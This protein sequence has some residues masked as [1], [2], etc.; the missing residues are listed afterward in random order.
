M[1][2]YIHHLFS[3]SLFEILFHNTENKEWFIRDDKTGYVTLEYKSQKYHVEFTNEIHDKQDGRHIISFYQLYRSMIDRDDDRILDINQNRKIIVDIKNI[4]KR[5]NEWIGDKKGWWVDIIFGE[6]FHDFNDSEVSDILKSWTNHTLLTELLYFNNSIPN[7]LF[8]L[9]QTLMFW[10]KKTN[11]M[12]Y[13]DYGK[14]HKMIKHPYPLGFQ[15]KRHRRRRLEIG[16]LLDKTNTFVSQ[17]RWVDEVISH[18]DSYFKPIEGA[19]VNELIGKSEFENRFLSYMVADKVGMDIF[20]LLYPQ[21]RIQILDETQSSDVYK[22]IDRINILFLSEKTWGMLIGNMGF[23][24]THTF[25]L[26]FISKQILGRPYPFYDKIK[27]LESDTPKL[28]E[29]INQI[30]QDEDKIQE[31]ESWVSEMHDILMNILLTENSILNN[32]EY[33]QEKSKLL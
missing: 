15:I 6:S 31:I 23:I 17:T 5:M 3:E 20:F 7:N 18:P 28:V 29:W 21:A 30:G 2:I 19:H 12:V 13:R 32:I 14:L 27:E 16:R 1:K 8:L 10:N 24:P 25:A 11:L 9:T 26:D 4:L 22:P 33:K